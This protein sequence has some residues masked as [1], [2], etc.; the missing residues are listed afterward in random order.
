MESAPPAG[1][2]TT[3]TAVS[4]DVAAAGS[5]ARRNSSESEPPGHSRR[6]P[7]RYQSAFA[8]LKAMYENGTSERIKKYEAAVDAAIPPDHPFV[9]RLDGVAFST[10]TAGMI[11]PFDSRLKDAMVDVAADLVNKFVPA[12]AY[13]HSDEISLVFLAANPLP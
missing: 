10:F 9:I 8:M 1:L 5:R 2:S 3:A 13:H 4:S 6:A 12:M 11:K 7:R